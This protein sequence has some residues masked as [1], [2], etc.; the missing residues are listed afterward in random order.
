MTYYLAAYAVFWAVLF[1]Y[2]LGLSSRQAK[3]NRQ[4]ETIVERLA[5]GPRVPEARGR[6]TS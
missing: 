2:L 1:G 4:A 3:L 6:E 5:S